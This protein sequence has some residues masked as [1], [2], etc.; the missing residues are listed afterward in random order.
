[1]F[2]DRYLEMGAYLSAYC[3]A[4]AVLIHFEVSAQQRV[5]T[6]QEHYH[7]ANPFC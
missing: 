4:T 7:R 2:T 3:I 1:M 6:N 5:Y